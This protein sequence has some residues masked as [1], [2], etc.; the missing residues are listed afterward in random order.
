MA[1]NLVN[2]NNLRSR[3]VCAICAD[4]NIELLES[5]DILSN[6]YICLLYVLPKMFCLEINK[7]K[8][9]G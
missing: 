5:I 8:I 6:Y 1:S 9:V 7:K 2:L 3:L 4:L